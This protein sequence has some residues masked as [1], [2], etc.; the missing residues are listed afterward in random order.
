[1]TLPD[2]A[3]APNQSGS[4]AVYELENAAIDPDGVLYDSMRRLAP[5]GPR[6]GECS[7]RVDVSW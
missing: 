4:P 5:W 3:Y 1:M 2:F 6:Y 7:V